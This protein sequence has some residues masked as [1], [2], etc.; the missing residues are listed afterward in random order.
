MLTLELVAVDPLLRGSGRVLSGE[1]R[2]SD[3]TAAAI[4]HNWRLGEMM[5]AL[6]GAQEVQDR[7]SRQT[8]WR[9]QPRRGPSAGRVGS[10]ID[11]PSWR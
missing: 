6:E 10:A 11:R 9:H 2:V 3:E 5:R 8:P 4:V 1:Q 7:R